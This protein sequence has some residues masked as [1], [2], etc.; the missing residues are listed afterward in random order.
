MAHQF[1]VF[2]E[3]KTNIKSDSDWSTSSIR[4]NG[5]SAGSI[6]ESNTVNTPIRQ[7]TLITTG[8]FDFLGTIDS[9][10]SIGLTSST[11][12]IQTYISNTMYTWLKNKNNFNATASTSTGTKTSITITLNETSKTVNVDRATYSTALENSSGLMTVGSVDSSKVGNP[13][14]FVN[15]IPSEITKVNNAKNA[16]K[17][18][19]ATTAGTSYKAEA[20][21]NDSAWLWDDEDAYEGGASAANIGSYQ[22][23]VYISDGKI[24]ALTERVADVLYVSISLTDGKVYDSTAGSTSYIKVDSKSLYLVTID[25]GNYLC[26]TTLLDTNLTGMR[27]ADA[28]LYPPYSDS[29]LPLHTYGQIE[30]S[31]SQYYLVVYGTNVSSGNTYRLTNSP[32]GT[33]QIT[34]K[35]GIKVYLRKIGRTK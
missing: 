6:I 18:T 11:S 34:L 30:I 14:C 21:V 17:A 22:K 19:Y 33:A 24:L 29:T 9:T 31:G 32:A 13:I 7:T 2:D 3:N 1:K 20:I 23:G 27:T 12:D 15:G 4:Q 28:L 25:L 26:F 35:N 10:T 5:Y 16:D 8:L